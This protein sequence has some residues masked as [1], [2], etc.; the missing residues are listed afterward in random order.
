[1]V[2]LQAIRA[3][4]AIPLPRSV[5]DR[6]E[7]IQRQLQD[8]IPH[9]NIRWVR[10][11]AIHVTLNFLGDISTS[12]VPEIEQAL[13]SVAH[14]AP[15]CTFTVTGL[16]CFPSLRRPRVVWVGITETSG[17]LAAL[18][19]AIEEAIAPL[20]FER[21][22]RAFTPH[23]T[24]GR[25][26]RRATRTDAAR[27]VSLIAQTE[28]KALGEVTAD[29]FCLIQSTLKPTGAEY[30]VIRQFDLRQRSSDIQR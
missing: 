26:S 27:I 11:A 24:L 3:F 6:V 28:A 14:H 2:P 23:L 15:E 20:G 10:S 18:Q 29:H 8:Y 9:R 30:T 12:K 16:S 21:E 19:T 4:T 5:L 13:Q 17:Q 22:C 7:R 1:M 25:V